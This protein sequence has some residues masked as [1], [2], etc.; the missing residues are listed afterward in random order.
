M[1]EVRRLGGAVVRYA[2]C[3]F[4]CS[5]FR[6]RYGSFGQE[7]PPQHNL[8]GAAGYSSKGQQPPPD[9]FHLTNEHPAMPMVGAALI[10]AAAGRGIGRFCDVFQDWKLPKL[11]TLCAWW[12]FMVYRP[13]PPPSHPLSSAYYPEVPFG[14][15][16]VGLGRSGRAGGRRSF[17]WSWGPG[18]GGRGSEISDDQPTTRIFF[19]NMC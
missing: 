18:G 1:P 2:A 11:H 19:F 3:V 9:H 14:Y 16:G 8:L 15:A 17:G 13:V 7:T 12:S 5:C 6:F 10:P 4:S